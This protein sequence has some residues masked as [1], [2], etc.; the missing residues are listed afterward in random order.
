VR[1]RTVLCF[2]ADDDKTPA[3]VVLS[4]CVIRGAD[5][6]CVPI[7]HVLGASCAWP[8]W[9]GPPMFFFGLSIS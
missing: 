3:S 1:E 8:G 6:L 2:G 5:A 4:Y 7:V 9:Q